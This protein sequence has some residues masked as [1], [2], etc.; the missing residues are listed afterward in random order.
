MT[1][2]AL[3]P[4]T[5][6]RLRLAF[7][8]GES[9]RGRLLLGQ[10]VP[11]KG[12]GDSSA[13]GANESRSLGGAAKKFHVCL[14]IIYIYTYDIAIGCHWYSQFHGLLESCCIIIG[15]CYNESRSSFPIS[16]FWRGDH[17]FLLY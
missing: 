3:K 13:G 17:W 7:F 15:S 11:A 9:R 1:E 10:A 6:S 8:E 5:A 2:A 12:D 16:V 14:T 4:A